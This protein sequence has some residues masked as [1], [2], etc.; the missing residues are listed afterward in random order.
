MSRYL[1]ATVPLSGHV[2]PG[3]PLAK[4]LV[5]KGHE[6]VW[7]SGRH[8]RERIEATGARFEPFRRAT[9]FRDETVRTQFG[10]IPSY[11]LLAHAG[12]YIR[13]VF[14]APMVAC[15]QDL[16]E[17]LA[18]FP[19]DAL[20]SDEWFTGAIP[21]A[22]KGVLPWVMYGNSPLLLFADN[23]PTPG[24]GLMP[25]RNLYQ[26]KQIQIANGI[27]R[28]LFRP[29]QHHID[30]RRA[31]CGLEKLSTFFSVQNMQ[32]AALVLKFNTEV[33]EFPHAQLPESVHF[34]GP[35]LPESGT[36]TS[37]PW[38]DRIRSSAQPTI[39]LTQGSVD[40][41]DI[42]KLILPTLK[43]LRHFPVNLLISTG[44][45][46]PEPLRKAFPQQHII[47]EPYIPYSLV[48]PFVTMMITNGGYG[49]VSTALSQGVPLIIAGNSEDKPEIASRIRYCGAGINLNTG[50]P[51]PHAIRRAV[52]AILHEPL[53]TA[54]AR[55]VQADYTRHDAV[56]ESI[57]LIE[58]IQLR[59]ER[60]AKK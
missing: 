52:R 59:T 20:I 26:R 25:P 12:Y 42:H 30:K 45:R 37:F 54:R 14:Y 8:F 53:F 34:V 10:K 4:R 15:Y 57:D 13:N 18:A 46:D 33:F 44:G 39:F 56:S 51:S 19:A 35:I 38:L 40:I 50:R 28:L 1:F 24:T 32:T 7:Y 55:R 27:G 23:F 58:E 36:V 11:S 22:E 49:G 9:D 47:I 2:N 16:Q 6:V 17:I 21:L 3:L 31:E 48:M 29:L 60:L 5:E 41:Y 43:A